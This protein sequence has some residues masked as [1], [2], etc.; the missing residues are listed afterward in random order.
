MLQFFIPWKRQKTRVFVDVFG[1][2]GEWYR[3]K[4]LAW[5]SLYS[6]FPELHSF[7]VSGFSQQFVVSLLYHDGR[8]CILSA[9]KLLLTARVGVTWT[10]DLDDRITELVQK[11]T[12]EV[13]EDGELY[14]VV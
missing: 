5:N 12:D 13:I 6:L 1:G 2:G 3:N 14:Y 10:L 4:T 11:Y 9:L 8:R 7:L